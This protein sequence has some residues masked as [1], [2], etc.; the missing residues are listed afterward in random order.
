MTV[1]NLPAEFADLS[2]FVPDWAL[3]TEK[4]RHIAMI[5]RGIGELRRFY[6]AMLPRYPAIVAH[7][8]RYPLDALP[9]D[10]QTLLDLA[11][12]FVET[13]HPVDL[14]WRTPDIEDTFPMGRL[15]YLELDGL[16]G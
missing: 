3:S 10:E 6:D 15:E 14:N 12:T 11:M 7:L 13:S 5:D 2:R 8:D 9:Q 16:N 1:Q 4:E